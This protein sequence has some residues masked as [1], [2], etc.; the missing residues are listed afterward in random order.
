MESNA[1]VTST[2]DVAVPLA[3]GKQLQLVPEKPY[4]R[5]LKN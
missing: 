1:L 5:L 2:Q 3:E 4:E